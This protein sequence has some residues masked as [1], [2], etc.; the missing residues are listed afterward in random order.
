MKVDK[1]FVFTSLALVFFV[2]TFGTYRLMYLDATSTVKVILFL[3]SSFLT[4]QGV[5]T[6]SWMLYAW[7]NPSKMEGRKSPEN[8]LTPQSSFTAIVP[9]RHEDK[10]VTDTINAINSIDYPNHLKEIIVV[11]RYDDERTIESVQK[12]INDIGNTNISLHVLG[13]TYPINK[14][15]SLNMGINRASKDFVAIFDAEDEPGRDIYKIVNTVLLRDKVDVVQSGVQLMNYDTHWFST[16]NVLEYFLWFKSGMHFFSDVGNVSVLGG[17]T[18]FFRRQLLNEING[19][20]DQ[21]LTEDADVGIRLTLA[22]AKTKVIYDERHVTKE[23]TPCSTESFIKQRTRWNHGFLQILS[24]GDWLK[25]P[26]MKQKLASM[27]VLFAPFFPLLM[28]F[29]IPF[30]L[31]TSFL[32]PSSVLLAMYSFVPFYILVTLVSIQI[33]AMWEFARIYD[34]K[35]YWYLPFKIIITYVPYAIL[36]SYS[37]LRSLVRFVF[38]FNAWEKTAH[39]NLHRLQA[40]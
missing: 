29:Y 4:I 30:G 26:T 13:E 25:L 40:L 18:V 8:Y 6:L 34:Q 19:W 2:S 22:G 17:N 38:G 5:I 11:V 31:V 14:P 28:I 1:T 24:K 37:S 7:N 33:V 36:L 21:A 15:F 16:L 39:L 23:E 27:Y 12:V 10:V 32:F 20:D 9:M 35:F 3:A